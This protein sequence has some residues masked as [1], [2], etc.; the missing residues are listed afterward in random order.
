MSTVSTEPL[1]RACCT[2]HSYVHSPFPLRNCRTITI[3]KDWDAYTLAL[4]GDD[5]CVRLYMRGHVCNLVRRRVRDH[6]RNLVRSASRASG[7]AQP[8]AWPCAR[9]FRRKEMGCQTLNLLNR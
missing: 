9:R 8:G 2:V 4:E 7:H 5:Y 1:H 6:V 3:A